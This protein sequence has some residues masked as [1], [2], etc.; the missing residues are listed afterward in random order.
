MPDKHLQASR[1]W[2]LVRNKLELTPA[3]KQHL[4]H[5]DRCHYWL[6]G[7]T[8]IA[9]RAGFEIAYTIPA[10]EKKRSATA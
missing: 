4:Q 3:E 8:E 9:R 1:G 10:F 6:S 7:F 5:C 2:S